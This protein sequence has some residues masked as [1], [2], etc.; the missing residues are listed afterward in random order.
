M[1]FLQGI[2][3]PLLF[4]DIG[5]DGDITGDILSLIPD[6]HD[7]GIDPVQVTVSGPVAE[8][9]MPYPCFFQ[10]CIHIPVK[11]SG[12]V[13]GA[14]NAVIAAQQLFAC[15]ATDLTEAVVDVGNGAPGIGDG[16]DGVLIEGEFLI[17]QGMQH[18]TRLF[19]TVTQRIQQIITAHGHQ[20]QIFA[21]LIDFPYR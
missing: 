4:T 15:I 7:A 18:F 11:V 17:L 12:M 21:Q 19:M 9:A 3:H 16:D 13:T 5:A 14:D 6:R 2:K 20:L 1:Q 8:F 10:C